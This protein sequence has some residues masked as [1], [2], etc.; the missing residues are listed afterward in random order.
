MGY[1]GGYTEPVLVDA[2]GS[3][4]ANSEN[5]IYVLSRG[6]PRFEKRDIPFVPQGGQRPNWLALAPDGSVWLVQR[7]HGLFLVADKRGDSPRTLTLAFADTSAF[8]VSFTRGQPAVL[9]SVSGRLVR[10]QLRGDTTASGTTNGTPPNAEAVPFSR[11]VGMSGD[12]V[13]AAMYDR[14][15]SLWIGTPTGIDRFRETKLTPIVWPRPVSYPGVAADT[16]GVVW[17]AARNAAPA[18]LFVVGDRV[19]TQPNAPGTF[20]CIYRDLDGGIWVGAEYTL[21]KRSGDALV[22]IPLPSKP[23]EQSPG[24]LPVHAI[25]RDRAGRLWVSIAT[26]GVYRQAAD[27]R[28]ERFGVRQKLDRLAATAIAT[29]SSGRT[30]LG[31]ANGTV[32]LVEEDSVHLFTAPD[33]LGVGGVLAITIRGNR[34]WVAGQAGVAAFLV[35]EAP[36]RVRP[37]VAFRTAGEPL[38]GVSGVVEAGDGELWVNSAVG[39]TRVAPNDVRQALA[40]SSYRAPFE[41]F[42][43]RDGIE[44]PAPQ[45]RPLPSAIEGTDGRLWFTSAGGVSWI[46][47]RRVRRNP[48]PPSVQLR[49]FTV[50]GRRNE[51]TGAVDDVIHLP[52]RTTSF[53]VAYTAYSLAVPERVLFQYRLDGLDTTWQDAGGR[54]EAFYTNLRPGPYRFH[55]RAANDDGVWNETGTSL[56]FDVRPAWYQTPW[57]GAFAVLLIAGL[58]AA[59]AAMIQ[60]SRHLRL[61][62]ALHAQYKATIAERSR[63]AQDLHDTLLQGFA[64][65]TLQLKA[66]EVALPEEPDVAVETIMRVQEL[67]KRSLREARERVWDMHETDLGADDLLQAL[68]AIVREHTAGSGTRVTVSATGDRRRLTRIVED[69]AFRVGREAMVNAVR[70]A[71]ASHIE[72]AL[73]FG[74]DVLRLTVRDD[75]RGFDTEISEDARRKGHFGLSGARERAARMGGKCEVH[76]RRGAGTVV[77]LELP[78]E[79]KHW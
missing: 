51:A 29:D 24:T 38:R 54:R 20:T 25:A 47:P 55:V 67:A 44:P 23:P 60:R 40:D 59:T 39:V 27:R 45:I 3:V 14:E 1:P 66:A 64:G 8:A 72:I 6:A 21:W 41:R 16:S 69:A 42:D 32:A 19:V 43:Y 37:F 71:E 5:G 11:A 76:S 33:G 49:S 53:S 58:G 79:R 52:P 48:I 17:V 77:T 2:R 78:L 18:A 73:D 35:A 30:W 12:R 9:N 50:N 34:T 57:F 61:Q 63:I 75:G 13:S 36:S 70:H 46:D 31:Y 26:D 15:G 68:E 4:W 65:V 7:P 62:S 74:A 22:P 28:W 10:F 56:G